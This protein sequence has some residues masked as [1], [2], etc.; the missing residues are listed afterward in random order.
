MAELIWM[1]CVVVTSVLAF[2]NRLKLSKYSEA[3]VNG[4][5]VSTEDLDLLA[6]T[7]HRQLLFN[8]E[9]PLV[10]RYQQRYRYA[11][12]IFYIDL[13]VS[14]GGL[15]LLL[16]KLPLWGA[17]AALAVVTFGLGSGAIY[18]MA[19]TLRQLRQLYRQHQLLLSQNIPSLHAHS[20]ARSIATLVYL[21]LL[22]VETCGFILWLSWLAYE[23]NSF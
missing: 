4:T 9:Q 13:V 18:S 17:F 5:L 15:L 1:G 2:I 10:H 16:T 12:I 19:R 11:L 22:Q 6:A 14:L 8:R 7:Y 3:I 23:I 20:Q 21:W